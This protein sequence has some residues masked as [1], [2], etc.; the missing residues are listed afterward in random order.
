MGAAYIVRKRARFVSING[1]VNLRYGT[2]V[3][4]VDGFLVHNGRPLCAV[5]SE[6]AHRYFAR[7]DDG[8]GKAR[9]ALI[10]ATRPSWSG[11]TPAIKCAGISC[12]ATRRRRNYATRIMRI[13]GCGA[14]PFLRRTWQTWNTS[15]ADRCEEVTLPWNYMKLVGGTSARHWTA[16]TKSPRHG[17]RWASA[18][19]LRY[20]EEMAAVR[21]DYDTAMGEVDPCKN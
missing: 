6:S 4:A 3:D 12:G 20:E 8:N 17:V 19:A 14:M 11:K 1:P 21:R 16:R 15:P 10:G 5:T 2:P 9:G 7:N 13:S 18:D